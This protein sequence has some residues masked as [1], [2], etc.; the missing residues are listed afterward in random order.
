MLMEK[1]DGN[2][3][4][5]VITNVGERGAVVWGEREGRSHCERGRGGRRTEGRGS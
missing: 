4:D 2:Q 1:K 5:L 3:F